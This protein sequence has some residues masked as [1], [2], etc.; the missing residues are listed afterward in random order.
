MAAR[1]KTT[2][3]VEEEIPEEI[4]YK[5]D[6]EG[7]S[8]DEVALDT[9]DEKV[10]EKP[11]E[12][13]KPVESETEE[14]EFDPAKLKAEAVAEAE[15]KLIDRLR[16][17]TADET[18]QNKDEYQEWADSF[19]QSHGGAV[20]TWKDAYQW[21][22]DRAVNRL[23]ERQTKKAAEAATAAATAKS[24]EDARMTNV[25]QYVDSQ[26]ADIFAT[27]K[28]PKIQ[29]KDNPSDPGNTFKRALTEQTMLINRERLDKG[30]PTKTIKEVF[31]EDF[32]S[33]TRQPAG[34]D[35]PVSAGRGA[36][37]T[38]DSTEELNYIRDVKNNRFLNSI[39]KR[40]G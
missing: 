3:T 40:R 5:K 28:V 14:I 39:F 31:Y 35:A 26:L 20:P 11:A 34:A 27:G 30:L 21:M 10:E 23:E 29:D 36:T 6:I 33:P 8:M 16:G 25:N 37:T 12:E 38:A 17:T 24:E 9:P 32:K 15:Q 1:K 2:T 19:A 18:A 7:K 13:E 22:E 4:D